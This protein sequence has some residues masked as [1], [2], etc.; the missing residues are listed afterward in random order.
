MRNGLGGMAD[1]SISK[2]EAFCVIEPFFVAAQIL[3]VQYCK[4]LGLDDRIKSTRLECSEE[5]HD[6][7]RHFAG[8]TLDG[9]K[10]LVA[11]E[12]AELPE[13]TVAAI[14][15]HEFGH[16]VD[17]QFPAYFVCVE[18]ELVFVG[19]VDVSTPRGAQAKVARMRQWEKRP[20]DEL[21]RLADLIAHQAT[22]SRIG[23]SGKCLLQGLNRGTP[24]PKG[25][26]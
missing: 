8:T 25:L 10:V 15:A 21:E 2:E 9:R 17:H 19:D 16:V 23:Y 20:V 24:R 14:M 5:I 1:S 7:D 4:D 6:T 13:D 3:F 22:G 26:R 12:M 11:P 18:D